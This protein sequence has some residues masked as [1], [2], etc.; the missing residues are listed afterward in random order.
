MAYYLFTEAIFDGE[1]IHLFNHGDMRRDFTY[2]DDVVKGVLAALDRPAL[3]D[4]AGV[5]HRVYNIGN[6]QS[7]ELR[8]FLE[9][10]EQAIGKKAE[11][12]LPANAARRRPGHLRRYHQ[13]QPRSRFRADN[14]TGRGHPAVRAVVPRLSRLLGCGSRR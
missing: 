2:I 3:A 12:K 1:P 13:C 8:R 5:R 4:E 9:I 11:I 7:V 6:N 10:I 14:R